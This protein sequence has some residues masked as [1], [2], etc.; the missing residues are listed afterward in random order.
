ME[1][2]DTGLGVQLSGTTFAQVPE[3]GGTVVLDV[4]RDVVFTHRASGER[5]ASATVQDR[6]VRSTITGRLSF[7][8]RVTSFET[9]QS[10]LSLTHVVRGPFL[11]PPVDVDFRL[12]GLGTVGPASATWPAGSTELQ[13]AFLPPADVTAARPSRF[14]FARTDSD[15]FIDT[16]VMALGLSTPTAVLTFVGSVHAFAPRS[17]ERMETSEPPEEPR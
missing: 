17:P 8:F 10:D 4:I 14:V 7:E 16:G 2:W 12:D 15:D 1:L 6:I 5:V 13:F 3:L 11:S 9:S